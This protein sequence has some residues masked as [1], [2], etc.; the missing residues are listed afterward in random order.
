MDNLITEAFRDVPED[1]ISDTEDDDLLVTMSSAYDVFPNSHP[2]L[3][4]ELNEL[5]SEQP[6]A[7][8]TKALVEKPVEKSNSLVDLV[9]E[10]LIMY[11]AALQNAKTAGDGSKA[12]RMD[13][14]LK[15]CI[16]LALIPFCFLNFEFKMITALKILKYIFFVEFA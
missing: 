8:T 2:C 14:G 10:R 16:C 13:R 9:E 7:P 12:R 1:D 15:V 6:V 5:T 3:Q 4:S 11:E